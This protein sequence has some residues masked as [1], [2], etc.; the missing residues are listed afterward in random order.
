M[1]TRALTRPHKTRYR[2]L[3]A[4]ILAKVVDA[5]DI[6]ETSEA[7]WVARQ[8]VLWLKFIVRRYPTVRVPDEWKPFTEPLGGIRFIWRGENVVV[9][10]RVFDTHN[11]FWRF[12]V[13]GPIP[14]GIISVSPDFFNRTYHWPM[15]EVPETAWHMLEI[16]DRV[17]F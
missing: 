14:Q 8:A 11:A 16:L 6:D 7:T 15:M 10:V 5:D 12:I 3:Q 2:E 17:F 13:D 9:E 4:L 1:V